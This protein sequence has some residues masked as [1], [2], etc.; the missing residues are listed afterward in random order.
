MTITAEMVKELRERTGAGM[1]DCKRALTEAG[2][3]AER[4]VEL[5]RE[6][7]LAS[8]AKKAGRAASEG[9]VVAYV[10]PDA[11]VGALVEVNCETD[12]V[13][14]NEEFRGFAENVAKAVAGADPGKPV[15]EGE[16]VLSLTLAGSGQTVEEGLTSLIAKLGENMAVRRYARFALAGPGRVESYIHLGGR[17]G[18][19]VEAAAP[20]DGA[21][22]GET[23]RQTLRDVAMQVAAAKP[24]YV[25]RVEVP[26][27]VRE[28]E[29]AIYRTLAASEGKPVQIQDR[30]AQGKLEKFFKEVCLLEQPFIRDPDKTVEAMLKERAK[31]AGGEIDVRRFVRFERGEG[32]VKQED[33]CC[34]GP[35]PTAGQ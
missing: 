32:L 17:I 20:S 11:R 7:G 3:N 8:A 21:A 14:R 26:T 15:G 25:N 2:G 6:R 9:L 24:E 1:M 28:R 34:P 10:T 29:L 22:A 18:V 31:E 5:L 30:I 13:A 33:G 4:A 16:A 35:A 12:F 23:F 19:L 27:Q